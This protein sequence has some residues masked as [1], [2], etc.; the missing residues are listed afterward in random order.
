M[1]YINFGI[2][3]IIDIK[4]KDMILNSTGIPNIL[5]LRLK[6][7]LSIITAIPHQLRLMVSGVYDEKTDNCYLGMGEKTPLGM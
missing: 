4:N 2:E 6:S 3:A 5:E 7:D 1:D